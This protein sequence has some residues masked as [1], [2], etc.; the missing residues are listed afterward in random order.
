MNPSLLVA[1]VSL[2]VAVVIAVLSIPMILRKVPMNNLYG[3]RFKESYTSEKNWYDINA[4]SGKVLLVASVP[5]GLW[6]IVGLVAPE[7][8]RGSYNIIAVL[9]QFGSVLVAMCVSYLKARKIV[10]ENGTQ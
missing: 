10:A 1:L 4:F 7:L 5:T 9:I 3:A 8:A 6:G 2:G